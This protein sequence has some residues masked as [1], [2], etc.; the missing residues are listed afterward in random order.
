M[1]ESVESVKFVA[2]CAGDTWR[3]RKLPPGMPFSWHSR[4]NGVLYQ[5]QVHMA[6]DGEPLVA[7]GCGAGL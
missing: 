7:G 6:D 1:F 2:P 4:H 5:A 3:E